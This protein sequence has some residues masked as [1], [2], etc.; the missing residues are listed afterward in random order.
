MTTNADAAPAAT[1]FRLVVERDLRHPP[2][3]VW[4]ALT[5]AQEIARW[6]FPIAFAP[7]VGHTFRIEGPAVPGWRG[8]T[9]CEVLAVDAPRRI[10]WSFA[11]TDG[12]PTIVAFTVMPRPDGSRLR[13]TH[14]GSVPPDTLVLLDRGWNLY[15][16]Q[17]VAM[18]G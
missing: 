6:F 8:F 9:D 1:D 7:V 2:A 11:C 12:P 15:A 16:D 17:L 3:R 4:R 5:D 18:L 13:I 14:H 10:V